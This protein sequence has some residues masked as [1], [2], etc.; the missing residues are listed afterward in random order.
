MTKQQ[1]ILWWGSCEK[2]KRTNS[3]KSVHQMHMESIPLSKLFQNA[4]Q[5]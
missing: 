3:D 2:Y 4:M 1:D 5:Q